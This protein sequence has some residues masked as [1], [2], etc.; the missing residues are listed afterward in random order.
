MVGWFGARDNA[1][2]LLFLA[3]GAQIPYDILQSFCLLEILRFA[4]LSCCAL[5]VLVTSSVYCAVLLL[6]SLRRSPEETRCRSPTLA[7]VLVAPD[8]VEQDGSEVN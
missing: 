5:S 2:L 1:H 6:V 7:L 8:K 4:F 3:V